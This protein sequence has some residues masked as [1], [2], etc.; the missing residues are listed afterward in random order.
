MEKIIYEVRKSHPNDDD[1][2]VAVVLSSAADKVTL[3]RRVGEIIE[4]S[5]KELNNARRALP[6]KPN[7]A[8]P[9]LRGSIVYI[10]R[11]GENGWS[12]VNQPQVEGAF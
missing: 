3:M 5:G 4:L 7:N 6:P 11:F 1:L 12:I 8:K 9:I 2:L 10:Q